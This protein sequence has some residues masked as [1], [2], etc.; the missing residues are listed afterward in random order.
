VGDVAR[1]LEFLVNDS[2]PAILFEDEHLLV[3][4][5]PAGI[6]THAPSPFAGEGLYDWLRHREPRWARLAIIHRLDKETSGVLVF[7]KTA[8][9]NRSLTDQFARR[10]IHKTYF[11]LT[12]RP[13]RKSEFRACSVIAR[14]GD[15]YASRPRGA[16]GERAQTNFRVVGQ[17]AGCTV[18][19]AEP[20]TGRTHQIRV[21]AADAGFPI[22]GDTGYGG[23]PH[24]RLCLHAQELVLQHP[25]TN[26]PIRFTIAADFSADARLGLRTAVIDSTATNVYRLVHGAADGWPG[27]YVDRVGDF[28]LS[29][30]ARALTDNQ[31]AAVDQWLEALALR[32]AYHKILDRHV[33]GTAT[34]M[35]SPMPVTG[36]IAPEKI[37]VHE[38]SLQYE[39]SFTEGY[40]VGLFFDQRDNRRRLLTHHVAAG[41]PLFE[42]GLEGKAV[43][44]TFAYTCGF[45]VCAARAGARVTSLDLSKKY[46]AWGQRNFALNALD[47]ANHEFICGDVFDWLRRW[48]KKSRMFD[49]V[50]LDPPT[51]SSSKE[52][53]RFQAEKDYG[54]LVA[55]ALRV[56][57]PGGVLF[58]STNAARLNPD[59]FL[60]A[61]ETAMT[62]AGRAVEGRH[63]T[64]QPPDFPISRAEP[65]HLKT[66]WWRVR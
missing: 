5:K 45:S 16:T 9:A 24:A 50:L 15:K 43:L 59:P 65:A 11:L 62:S 47:P 51:F 35:V 17:L 1:R 33:R 52:H 42:S 27:W 28:L 57:R 39:L 66:A 55:A 12:D 26:E 23:T 53:G 2:V 54:A 36:E 19:E 13:V 31:R 22:L 61:V 7:G 3:V 8:L 25:Q 4:N 10:T 60:R 21:H 64:P 14:L 41:F 48:V 18:V 20:V 37:I 29:Q 38:N 44:N 32:G 49:V 56:L 63:Y 46:L 30:S 34:T 58:A 40:S 6:N